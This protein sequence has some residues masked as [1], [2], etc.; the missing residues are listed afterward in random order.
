M[1]CSLHLPQ[2]IYDFVY[3]HL[4]FNTIDHLFIHF[5]ERN[6]NIHSIYLRKRLAYKNRSVCVTRL[7]FK[8]HLSAHCL[9]HFLYS[10]SLSSFFSIFQCVTHAPIFFCKSFAQTDRMNFHIC[11]NHLCKPK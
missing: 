7:K 4:F 3:F 9:L 5:Q 6:M 1:T 11:S 8:E 10:A 2:C